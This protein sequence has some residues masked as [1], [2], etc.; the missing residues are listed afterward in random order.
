MG[1]MAKQ[2]GRG[3]EFR[4]VFFHHGVINVKENGRIFQ[5]RQNTAQCKSGSYSHPSE[6]VKSSVIQCWYK[7]KVSNGKICSNDFFAIGWTKYL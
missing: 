2:L 6:V 5:A 4:I 7:H 3:L 1:R